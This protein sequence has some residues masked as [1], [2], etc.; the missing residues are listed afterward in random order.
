MVL[1]KQKEKE[2][3]EGDVYK[4]TKVSREDVVRETIPQ[5]DISSQTPGWL[6]IVIFI[7]VMGLVRG[8]LIPLMD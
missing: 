3:D 5:I 8:L 4:S 1:E 2:D 6:Y 7:I